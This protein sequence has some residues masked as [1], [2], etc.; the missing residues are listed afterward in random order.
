MSKRKDK[1]KLRR[2]LLA[3]WVK[4]MSEGDIDD[5]II[6]WSEGKRP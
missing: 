3:A 2:R 4:A 6:V 1:P 5:V